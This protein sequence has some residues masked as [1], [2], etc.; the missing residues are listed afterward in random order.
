MIITPVPSFLLNPIRC[1]RFIAGIKKANV[2]PEPVLAD[3]KISWPLRAGGIPFSCTQVRFVKFK[4]FKAA[5]SGS[6][7]S[8]SANLVS[9][10]SPEGAFSSI[11]TNFSA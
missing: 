4:D 6:Q 3:P 10:K 5:L 7:I 8:R 9:L 1:K 2:F 11:F